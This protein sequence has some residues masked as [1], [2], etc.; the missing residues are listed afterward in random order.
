LL[1]LVGDIASA[2]EAVP[3]KMAAERIMLVRVNIVRLHGCRALRLFDAGTM[4][5]R[6]AL[7]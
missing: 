2:A 4:P 1:L 3:R 5:R 6:H 7:S